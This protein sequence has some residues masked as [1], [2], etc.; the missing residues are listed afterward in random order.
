LTP[1]EALRTATTNV[2]R[3]LGQPNEFGVIKAG[4][5][6]DLLLLDANPLSDISATRRIGGVVLRGRW[7]TS[8]A[9]DSL[10][11]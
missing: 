4:A 5:R 9:L 2:A 10:R 7:L 6:A 8:L 11:N 1:F 3:F